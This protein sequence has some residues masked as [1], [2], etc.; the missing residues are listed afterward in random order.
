MRRKTRVKGLTPLVTW[1]RRLHGF[2]G[3]HPG[4]LAEPALA[5]ATSGASAWRCGDAHIAV[6]T[7]YRSTQVSGD[8]REFLLESKA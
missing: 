5:P 2:D 3:Y 4:R 6:Q 1:L 7:R 8:S